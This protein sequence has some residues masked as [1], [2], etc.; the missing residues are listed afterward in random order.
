MSLA[1]ENPFKVRAFEKAAATVGGVKDL[2][3]RA[4]AG[5]LTEIAGIGK[6]IA[7]VLTDYFVK[8]VTPQLD[9]VK[10]KISP[11]LLEL[12]R[13]RGLGPKKAQLLIDELGIQTISELEYAC[14][15][16]RLLKLKGFGEKLQQKVLEQIQFLNSTRGQFRLDVARAGAAEVEPA[17][18]KAL[19]K[20]GIKAEAKSGAEAFSATGAYRRELEVV[21][22]LEYLVRLPEKGAAAVREKLEK[23]AAELGGHEKQPVP[24][25]LAFAEA[26]RYGYELARTTATEAHWK[27][28]GAPKSFAAASETDFYKKIELPWIGPEMRESGEEVELAKKGK[29]E[30]ILAWDGVQGVFHNHSTYSDGVNTI[31]EMVEG[32]R[33]LGFKYIGISDHS[34]SAFYAQGLKTDALKK[35]RKEIDA[36]REKYDDIEIFWGVESDIL[37]DGG[38]D[39]DEKTLAAFDFVVASIH[40]RFQMDRKA[41]T[42]R[43]LK[44]VRHPATRFLGHLTGRLLLGRAGFDLDM[45]AVIAECAKRDVAIEINANPARLDIDWR[46]GPQLRAHE[47]LVSV[48]PDAH[49]VAGLA[50]TRYGVA[51]ARKA[52]LPASLVVNARSAKDVGRWLKRA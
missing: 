42:E 12:V 50:D 51:V 9:A 16:N 8:D 37:A 2:A 38:L 19:D 32:A 25:K 44:A 47:T 17:L 35:Q 43:V 14:R 46:F 4:R 28:L 22:A 29:L 13:V 49:E 3:A 24:V 18:K 5:T 20:L 48:N 31:A 27:K 21:E 10:S 1:G 36:V 40:S 39:Y 52:L 26:D 45:E 33:K 11:A 7:E 30:A 15:E 34:Q 41:M 6:G 23:L